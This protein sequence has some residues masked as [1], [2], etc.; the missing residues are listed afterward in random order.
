[1]A[2]WDKKPVMLAV[3]L[4]K[5]VDRVYR[6][7]TKTCLTGI[8]HRSPVDTGQYRSNHILSIG[9]PDYSVEYKP[10]KKG[11]R[12]LR[13]GMSVLKDIPLGKFP[14]VFI[15]NNLPYGLRLENGWSKQ[16]PNGVYAM[17]FNH[18]VQAYK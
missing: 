5:K 2:G 12:T 6:G 16:A 15:Q 13:L 7:F 8:V 14:S 1:M 18:A 4:E 11:I 9:K 3:A 10:D 17:S